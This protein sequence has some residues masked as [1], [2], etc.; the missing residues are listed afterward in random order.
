MISRVSIVLLVIALITLAALQYHWIGQISEAERQ[1]LEASVK[2]S[3]TRFAG[4]FIGEI[5]SMSTSLD[6]RG[7]EPVPAAIAARYRSWAE[8]SGYPDL[9]RTLYVAR[10]APTGDVRLFQINLQEES[11]QLVEWPSRLAPLRAYF[12]REPAGPERRNIS[13]APRSLPWLDGSS[14]VLIPLTGRP[15]DP[16]RGRGGPGPGPGPGSGRGPGSQFQPP[17]P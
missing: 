12:Q 11:Q 15:A 17:P 13:N 10:S 1:R 16:Q 6:F 2:D 4:D 9:V 3:S 14:A 5:R 8:T 7:Y